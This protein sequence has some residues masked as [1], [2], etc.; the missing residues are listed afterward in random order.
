M[1]P[2]YR[3]ALPFF[4]SCLIGLPAALVSTCGARAAQIPTAIERP[5]CAVCGL[6]L[7]PDSSTD[8]QGGARRDGERRSRGGGGAGSRRLG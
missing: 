7:R 8:W 5:H 3:R 6:R 2:W 1:G 4:S